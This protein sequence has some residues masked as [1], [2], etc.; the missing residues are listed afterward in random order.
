M[1]RTGYHSLALAML[2]GLAMPVHAQPW[3]DPHGYGRSSGPGERQGGEMRDDDPWSR[4]QGPIRRFASS[5]ERRPYDREG[6]SPHPGNAERDVRRRH[7]GPGL[8]SA[9]GRGVQIYVDPMPF[10]QEQ[11]PDPAARPDFPRG[12]TPWFGGQ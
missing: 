4:H 5:E 9:P 8:P 2:L 3:P 12:R 6:P 7:S 11:P 1:R 10:L